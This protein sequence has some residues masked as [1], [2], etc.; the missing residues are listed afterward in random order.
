M[1]AYFST[2]DWQP[3]TPPILVGPRCYYVQIAAT[4][5]GPSYFAS[6]DY[7]ELPTVNVS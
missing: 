5:T 4:G 3:R 6:I 1:G 7:I 2:Y